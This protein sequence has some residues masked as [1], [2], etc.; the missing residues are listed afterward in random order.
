MQ[1]EEEKNNKAE[2][3]AVDYGSK[4]LRFYKTFEEEQEVQID[5]WRG[6]SHVERMAQLRS[7]SYYAFSSFE[8]Y[9]GNRLTF[10]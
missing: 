4:R 3:P 9:E 5:Y 8:K 10:D 6:L 7:I 1:P 2:E